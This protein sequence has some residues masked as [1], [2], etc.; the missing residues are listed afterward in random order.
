MN[1]NN[2]SEA[3]RY[4][5]ADNEETQY[6]GVD[7]EATQYQAGDSEAT[8]FGGS[9]SAA[10][11]ATG[12]P[13]ADSAQSKPSR[14]WGKRA[15]VGAG[16]GVLIGG[17]TT[18]LM[19]MNKDNTEEDKKPGV[20]DG[21]DN[22]KDELSHPEWVDD[23]IQVATTVNDDMSFDEAFAA[24][25]AELGPG[26]CFEWHGQVYATYN[27]EEWNGMTAQERA[28]FEDH[29]SWN[30]IDTTNSDVAQHTTHSA[31]PASHAQSTAHTETVQAQ[32]VDSDDDDIEVVSVDNPGHGNVAQNAPQPQEPQQ[33]STE[34]SSQDVEI[35]GVEHD[36][37]TGANVGQMMVDG[38][39]VVLIDVDNDMEFDF[40]AM[41]A[42]GN[43][44]VDDGEIVDIQGQGLTVNDL[45]GISN[46]GGGMMAT[47]DDVDYSGDMPYEG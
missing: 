11:S 46:P 21:K 5:G 15:A 22:H 32:V 41:D 37:E 43:G 18:V 28:Q 8:R 26:G 35:L 6:C 14:G 42:N 33:T 38:H 2:D 19:G 45:G 36:P 7:N 30:H 29:F 12:A 4:Q 24:A 39:Q 20:N 31:Q 27:A 34:I 23:N 16:S 25:R 10:Q 47:T 9:Q 3:T 17:V 44:T 40:M 1:K 13:A